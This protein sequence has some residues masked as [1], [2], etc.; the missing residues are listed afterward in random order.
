MNVQYINDS[1]GNPTG[2][3][4]PIEEWEELEKK[5]HF[6]DNLDLFEL[7]DHQKNIL[8]ERLKS[9]KQDFIPARKALEKI[10]Q[11]YEL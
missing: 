7:T 2:V 10:R 9:D 5:Y 4:I 11:K 6:K 1:Q 3:F 8:D